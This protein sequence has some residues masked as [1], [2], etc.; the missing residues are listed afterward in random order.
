MEIN[1]PKKKVLVFGVFDCLHDG[2]R[3]LFTH[4]KILGDLCIVVTPDEVVMQLKNHTP[5]QT[6]IQRIAVLTREF[7]DT[8]IVK[9][10]TELNSWNI[11]LGEK[12]DIVLLGY[13]QQ[14]LRESLEQ[15]LEKNKLPISIEVG[16]PYKGDILHSSML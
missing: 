6:I 2:H 8:R 4:A 9:G 1:N 12:P 15:F 7:P 3:S 16:L 13:D 14:A 11:L 5:R 10:D